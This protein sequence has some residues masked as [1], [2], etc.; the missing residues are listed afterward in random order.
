[1][2]KLAIT[3][4]IS[5]CLAL[6]APILASANIQSAPRV[7]IKPHPMKLNAASWV[8]MDFETGDIIADQSMNERRSSASLTKTMTAYIIASELKQKT[9]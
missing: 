5:A 2:K 8:L 6:L 1:M 7:I 3:A 4:A 9:L